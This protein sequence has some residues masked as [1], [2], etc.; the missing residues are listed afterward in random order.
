MLTIHSIEKGVVI[1]HIG[2]G[3]A[4]SIYHHLGLDR[5]DCSV[6]IIMNARSEKLGKKDIIKIEDRI[7]LDL[8]VLG[9]MD[10]SATV[11]IIED[12]LITHKLKLSLPDTL[13]D[14]IKCKNPRCVT[15]IERG[16]R[17]IFKLYDRQHKIY[18]CAYCE[19]EHK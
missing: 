7:D 17:Q 10:A 2:V 12:G 3:G 11:N 19:Q 15:S 9:Y 6:A 14:V 18:R 4:M 13:V 8:D 1:D 5:L 16:I